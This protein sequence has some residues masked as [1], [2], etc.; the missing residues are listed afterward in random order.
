MNAALLV[1][2]IFPRAVHLWN[3]EQ[4]SHREPSS[5]APSSSGSPSSTTRLQV[6]VWQL[7]ASDPFAWLAVWEIR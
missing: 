4:G 3:G 7:T 2:G 6:L 5:N 1:G